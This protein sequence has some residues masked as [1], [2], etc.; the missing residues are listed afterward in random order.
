MI[1]KNESFSLLL[2]GFVLVFTLSLRKETSAIPF[3]AL[4]VFLFLFINIVT[5]KIIGFY[6]GIDVKTK[7]WNIKKIFYNV[8]TKKSGFKAGFFF[9]FFVGILSAGYWSWLANFSFE[10]KALSYRSAKRYGIKGFS[11]ITESHIAI[12]AGL[13][14]LANFVAGIL[15]YLINL[16]AVMEFTKLNFLFVAFNLLPVSNLDGNKI[17]FGNKILWAFLILITLGGLFYVL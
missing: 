13:A 11:E 12:I 14:L 2:I 6:L 7:I 16:P 1:D 15:G 5:K 9:P 8:Q 3:I 10:V 17:L 4:S